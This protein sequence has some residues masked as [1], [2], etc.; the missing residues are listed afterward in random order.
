MRYLFG[1]LVLDTDARELTAG[2]DLVEVEPQA[3][4]VLVHLVINRHR[5]VTKEELLDEIWGD[6]FVSE[7]A[8]TTRIKQI[9]QAV[10][11]DGRS[12]HVVKTVHRRGY[13]FVA[14][15]EEAR[16]GG[17]PVD[18]GDRFGIPRAPRTSYARG[19]G[20][21][22]AYQTFGRGP[23]LVLIAGFTTNVE[24]QWEHPTPAGFLQRLGSF[25][26]VTVLDKRGVGLSDRMAGDNPP[27]LETRADD[28]L[29]VMDDA[30]IDTA[31]ILGSSEGGALSSLFAASHPER[32]EGLILH[33]TWVRHPSGGDRSS[34][35]ELAEKY[36][37]TGA[38]FADL[39][40]DMASTRSGR[41]FL[42]RY[43]RQ[44]ASPTAARLLRELSGR[45]DLSGVVDA[46][47][48]PTLVIHRRDDHRIPFWCGEELAARIP[49][50][51]LLELSGSDHYIFSGDTDLMLDAIEEFVTGSRQPAAPRVER[52]LATVLFVDIVGSTATAQQ[53]GDARW[54]ARLD[55]F[56]D[57]TDR[58]LAAHK[59][60]LVKTTGDGLLAT[61]DAPGR[62]V[63]AACGLRNEVA[64]LGL[65]IR[66]GLHT[67]EIE[68][69]GDD[70]AGIGV[71]IASRVAETAGP[72]EV[73]VSRTVT[74]LVAGTGLDFIARGDHEL[75]GL[76][77]SWALYEVN[78]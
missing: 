34:E 73:W 65:Q 14:D 15:V 36:W 17:E 64:P 45:I 46:I 38:V 27:S 74:D 48:V 54:T 26:R 11:D 5:V 59:G 28:L 41:R 55:Q 43:E 29:A 2:G 8:L 24:L 76:D 18:D 22:I 72:G 32:V 58:V 53:L 70:I 44:S 1:A 42:A 75:K 49:D 47:A 78:A 30:E 63:Q 25:S 68:R 21:S 62:G 19:D 71:H 52:Q 57:A 50:A 4:D 39:A 77:H 56:H 31:T 33:G 3:F 12:Q 61:F 60:E 66:S 16:T 67:A 13:R 51:R 69:R 6:R 23:D 37:G 7:S 35:A 20:A 9:R 10:N 40:P